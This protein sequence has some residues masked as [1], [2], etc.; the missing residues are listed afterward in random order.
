[1]EVEEVINFL[2]DA[3]E[4]TYSSQDKCYLSMAIETLWHMKECGC[5]NH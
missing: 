5:F 2:K 4:H 1:M 3:K